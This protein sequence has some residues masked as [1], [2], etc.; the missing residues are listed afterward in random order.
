MWKGLEST[1][2]NQLVLGFSG[3]R[4]EITVAGLQCAD[5]S[6][7]RVGETRL[8]DQEVTGRGFQRFLLGRGSDL[9]E[10]V[11]NRALVVVSSPELVTL[12][13]GRDCAR[14]GIDAVA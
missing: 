7:R 11:L 14:A 3:S 1:V 12:P 5:G 9:V 2:S 10:A 8:D 13:R 6:S 4:A